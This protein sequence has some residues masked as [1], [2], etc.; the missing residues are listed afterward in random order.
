MDATNANMLECL[1]YI[2]DFH[3]NALGKV[4]GAGVGA[5]IEPNEQGDNTTL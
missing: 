4:E 1:N 2:S 5:A 3:E